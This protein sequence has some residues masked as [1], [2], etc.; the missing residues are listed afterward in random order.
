MTTEMEPVLGDWPPEDL[1]ANGRKLLHQIRQHLETIRDRPVTTG[2]GAAEL[3]DLISGPLPERP[4]SFDRILEDTWEKVVPNL[5][6]WHHP[7][8]HAYF[9]NS[10]S[11]PAMLAELLTATLNVNAQQWRTAPAASAVERTVLQWVAE[12]ADYPQTADGVLVNGASLAT[13]YALTAAR[14]SLTDLN[15][16]ERGMAG[17]DMP[18]LRIYASDQTHSSIDKAAIALGIGTD[19]VV[20]LRSDEQNRFS[21]DALDAAIRRD[22]EAGR[23][24]VAVVGTVGTTSTCA[25]DPLA[26]L[27]D[28]CEEHGVW[29]H[30]DAAY[31]GLW[32]ITD[33]LRPHLGELHFA[34]S[35]IVNPHKVLFCPMEVSA[36]YCKRNGAL[37]NAFRLVPEYLRT[38]PDEAAVDYMNHSLQ[39]GRQFRAL[40][41]WWVIRSFGRA[42]LAARMSQAV[43]M[44]DWLREQARQHHQWRVAESSVLPLVCLRY[45]PAEPRLAGQ[46]ES[47]KKR[48]W[49][50][51]NE[52]IVRKVYESGQAYVSHT[53]TRAGYV[54]R[55]S[56]GNIQTTPGD[57]ERAWLLLQKVA[58]ESRQQLLDSEEER[59]TASDDFYNRLAK[60]GAEARWTVGDGPWNPQPWSVPYLW[61]YEDLRPLAIESSKFVRGDEAALRVISLVNPGCAYDLS[62]G[63]VEG[64]S[65]ESPHGS[66]P[67]VGHLYTGLQMLNPG[68]S[69]T[70]HRH[71]ATAIRLV[72]EGSEAWTIIDGERLEVGP[73]DFVVTPSRL[74]HEH[75]SAG[76]VGDAPVIWQD[77]TDDPLVNTLDA[78]FYEQY[79]NLHQA[80]RRSINNSLTLHGNG[81]LKPDAR[82]S[83]PYSPL[84]A[85]PWDKTYE[86]LQAVADTTDGS[87]YDGFLME[88]VNPAT[89]GSATPS[90]GAH[91]QLLK[92][93]QATRA[94][95]HTGSAVY[96]VVKGRGHSVIAGRRFDWK[97]NDIFCV[98]SWAWHE[99]ANDDP[100]NDACLFSF[101]DFP[102][103]R[104][105]DLF[106]EEAFND[107]G[108]H[109]EMD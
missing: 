103:M 45:E 106:I 74:W 32:R 63:L 27:A 50:K 48:W 87:P 61:K 81:L 44:A 60:L 51:L 35:A 84:L 77:G 3:Q 85:Y 33:Q 67:A 5:S 76:Q 59:V 40:K 96:Q 24:P 66:A 43:D 16:R 29:L 19:N 23:R 105:L 47:D 46:S 9:S 8:F 93:G 104:N 12:M 88:Y 37:S 7:S 92:P 18:A 22:L 90:I 78:N 79:P 82:R 69:M 107:N 64:K 42:G 65:V 68:E 4:E 72:I 13:L 34:D 6:L 109:Q 10:S 52:L 91:A 28:V 95:R 36:L 2:I 30:V 20:R 108:G 55:V 98:P 53:V 86:T 26:E 56:I 89:G 41:L 58:E 57:V 17:R 99:H 21:S 39:L 62:S 100:S 94:H 38:D 97:K 1:E 80:Q 73:G 54:I 49:D 15:I 101:N 31:G 71:A 102:V 14:D 75:G 70:A 25:I 11:G 83:S